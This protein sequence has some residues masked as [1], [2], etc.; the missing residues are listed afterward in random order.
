MRAFV[1]LSSFLCL[2]SSQ[3]PS[4]T[5]ADQFVEFLFD[6]G[7]STPIATRGENCVYDDKNDIVWY[8]GGDNSLSVRI[9]TF[10]YV[11]RSFTFTGTYSEELI[12]Y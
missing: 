2:V 1:F 8:L 5:I 12:G 4:P 10:N 7:N 9:Y 3:T 11:N 6:F